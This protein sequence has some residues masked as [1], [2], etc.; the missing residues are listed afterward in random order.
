MSFYI[1]GTKTL[2]IL[3]LKIK[4]ISKQWQIWYETSLPMFWIY[5]WAASIILI[6]VIQLTN[7]RIGYSTKAEEINTIILQIS[8]GMFASCFFYWINEYIPSKALRK[9]SE[10][11][12]SHEILEIRKMIQQCTYSIL[13]LFSFER[14]K[15]LLRKEYIQKFE[16]ANLNEKYPIGN[17]TIA[18]FLE[19]KRGCIRRKCLELLDEYNRSLKV[20]QLKYIHRI[21]GSYFILNQIAPIDF[22][23]PNPIE[24][25]F[26]NNQK[27]MGKSIYYLHS[28]RNLPKLKLR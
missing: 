12:I 10:D 23:F 26:P 15:M 2:R 17:K 24:D 22:S 28:L 8:I 5:F 21:L 14:I 7:I 9:I 18:E 19:E 3:K 20:S 1:L 6:V 25:N 27:E 4:Q 13:P 16:I 11:H